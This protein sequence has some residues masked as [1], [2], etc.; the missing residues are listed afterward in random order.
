MV[1]DLLY[2]SLQEILCLSFSISDDCLY[3][4]WRYKDSIPG[5]LVSKI[6]LFHQVTGGVSLLKVSKLLTHLPRPKTEPP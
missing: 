1:V 5:C 6:L 2:K 3:K 4:E